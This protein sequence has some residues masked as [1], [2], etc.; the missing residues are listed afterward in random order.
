MRIDGGWASFW[1][2]L[3]NLCL[4]RGAFVWQRCA[5]YGRHLVFSFLSYNNCTLFLLFAHAC[6][7]LSHPRP[8]TAS[9]SWAWTRARS[10]PTVAP[11]PWDTPWAAPAPA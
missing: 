1:A 6:P 10:T 11:L 3:R 9:R 2:A 7:Y 5:V 8:P 4:H